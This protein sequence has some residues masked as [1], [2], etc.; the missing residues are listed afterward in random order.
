MAQQAERQEAMFARMRR[1][2]LLENPPGPGFC[3]REAKSCPIMVMSGT[4]IP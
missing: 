2:S 3:L 1:R 4:L